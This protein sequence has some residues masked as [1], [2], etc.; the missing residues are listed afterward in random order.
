MLPMFIY[1]YFF[2]PAAGIT[3]GTAYG[4]LQYFQDAYSVHWVQLILDYPVAFAMM[5]LAGLSRKNLPLGALIGGAGRLLVHF[6]C[7]FVFFAHYAPEGMN[8]IYYSLVYNFSSTGIDTLICVAIAML[9][10][11][12]H[13]IGRVK[14]TA[15]Q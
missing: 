8:P 5:G 7:G 9:P 12:K 14:K 6:I 4:L 1:G 3:A 15:I 10:Q 2:G 13:A 11:V